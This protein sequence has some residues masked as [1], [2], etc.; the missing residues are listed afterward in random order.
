LNIEF[1]WVE[2]AEL[3]TIFVPECGKRR[4]LRKILFF[5]L[6]ILQNWATF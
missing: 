1:K 6:K 2:K 5:E 4:V 3:L